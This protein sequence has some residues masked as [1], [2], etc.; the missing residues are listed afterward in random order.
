MRYKLFTIVFLFLAATVVFAC[1]GKD[2]LG[3][4]IVLSTSTIT[5]SS[6][7]ITSTPTVTPEATPTLVAPGVPERTAYL[8]F[9]P[10]CSDTPPGSSIW[11]LWPP[12]QT[13]ELILKDE[14]FAITQLLIS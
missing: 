6:L 1:S 9:S 13:A 11:A 7:P 12:F 2:G 14:K 8:L 3:T 10:C 4:P 5:S